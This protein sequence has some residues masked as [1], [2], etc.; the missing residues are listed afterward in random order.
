MK[1]ICKILVINIFKVR[2]MCQLSDE[3]FVNKYLVGLLYYSVLFF[4]FHIWSADYEIW[5]FLRYLICRSQNTTSYWFAFQTRV[6]TF[7]ARNAKKIILNKLQ[8]INVE[9]FIVYQRVTSMADNLK[10]LACQRAL[11]RERFRRCKG[12]SMF[13]RRSALFNVELWP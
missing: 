2:M 13:G 7:S 5:L 1:Y 11:L 3:S 6:R 8:V 4:L 9:L 12:N 10:S